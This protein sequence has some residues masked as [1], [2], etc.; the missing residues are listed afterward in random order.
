ML[1]PQGKVA[2]RVAE[3]LAPE[4]AANLDVVYYPQLGEHYARYDRLTGNGAITR[5][6]DMR[7]DSRTMA[8]SDRV[9]G[10]R[11]L[12]VSGAKVTLKCD[13]R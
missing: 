12:D 6:L 3:P 5:L 13:S 1:G 11:R 4:L 2:L 8:R 7:S 9:P 10:C